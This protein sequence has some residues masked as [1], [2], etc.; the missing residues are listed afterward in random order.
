MELDADKVKAEILRRAPQSIS[1]WQ[2][3]KVTTEGQPGARLVHQWD[4]LGSRAPRLNLRRG[5]LAFTRDFEHVKGKVVRLAS[6]AALV[7]LLAIVSAGV[8][9]FADAFPDRTSPYSRT[10]AQTPV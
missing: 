5:D 10:G 9:A 4:D 1:A 7:V 8:K 2:G 3:W 6:Y